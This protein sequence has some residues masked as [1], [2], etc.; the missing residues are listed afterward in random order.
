MSSSRE[1]SQPRNQ[2]WVSYIS[3]NAGGFF[4]T[5]ATWVNPEALA[6]YTFSFQ[7]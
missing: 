7:I 6:N 4:T 2:T 3:C 1:S 5:S